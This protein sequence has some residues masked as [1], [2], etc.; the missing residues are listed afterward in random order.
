MKKVYIEDWSQ[1]K[2]LI[3]F[4]NQKVL[5]YQIDSVERKVYLEFI[6]N[7]IVYIYRSREDNFP[8]PCGIIEEPPDEIFKLTKAEPVS[9]EIF[10]REITYL[11][12][13]QKIRGFNMWCIYSDFSKTIK[14][15]MNKILS[16][17]ILIEGKIEE[18]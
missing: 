6:D 5:H 4:K 1:F 7:D 14:E 13:A 17:Y 11:V 12:G 10:G 15:E 3:D 18:E 2:K 8:Y 9:N 16:N